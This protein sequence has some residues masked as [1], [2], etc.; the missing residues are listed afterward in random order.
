MGRLGGWGAGAET[1]P[2]VSWPPHVGQGHTH[3][4]LLHKRVHLC[5]VTHTGTVTQS[6][7]MWRRNAQSLRLSSRHTEQ[8]PGLAALAGGPC[9]SDT[10]A[11]SPTLGSL[12]GRRSPPDRPEGP[13]W[14]HSMQ[15]PACPEARLAPPAQGPRPGPQETACSPEVSTATRLRVHLHAVTRPVPRRTPHEHTRTP[16]HVVPGPAPHPRS[17]PGC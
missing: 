14:L 8:P 13:T 10:W 16:P 12:P 6:H 5:T 7:V 11:C 3:L 4:C 1:H 2:G 15:R 17:S 9:V